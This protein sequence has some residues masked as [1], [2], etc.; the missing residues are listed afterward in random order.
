[1]DLS[2]KKLLIFRFSFELSQFIIFSSS[3]A[4]NISESAS[5]YSDSALSVSRSSCYFL[6]DTHYC[7]NAKQSGLCQKCYLISPTFY[8]FYNM[9]PFHFCPY[10]LLYTGDFTFIILYRYLSP[11]QSESFCSRSH[12]LWMQI[13]SSEIFISSTVLICCTMVRLIACLAFYKALFISCFFMILWKNL[14]LFHRVS[15]LPIISIHIF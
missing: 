14:I 4:W 12:I 7:P 13:F 3:K 6:A 9:D 5:C 8:S 1:M 2:V 10:N 15:V 11:F